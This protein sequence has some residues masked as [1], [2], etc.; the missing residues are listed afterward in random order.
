M[1]SSI[2]RRRF[3]KGTAK[4]AV[5][6]A[7]FPS[8]RLEAAPSFDL[9]IKGGTILD[10]TGGNPWKTD[11]G[12][13]GDR[14]Q[15]IGSISAGQGKKVL[16]VGGLHVSPGF[17]DIHTHSDSTLPA[18]TTADSRVR[19]GVTTEVTGNCGSSAAPRVD[20][21][22]DRKKWM[23]DEG[24]V[25]D[26][27]DVATYFASLERR[28]FSLNQAMLLGQGTIRKNIV[29]LVD[30]EA[31]PDEMKKILR[32]LEDGMDQGAIGL[33]TGLEYTPGLY[34][35]TG[36][37]IDMAR[38]VSRR[39]GLYASHIRNEE[40]G[41]LEAINE[42]IEIGRRTGVRVQIS[43]LKAAGRVNWGKQ[44]AA[45]DLI[46]SAKSEGIDILADAYPYTAYSTTLTVL[47][48]P[49][50]LDGG[51]K[52]MMGRLKDAEQRARIR[53]ELVK[54]I[55]N[56]PGDY[57]LIVISDLHSQ[58]NKQCIGMNMKQIGEM[59]SVEPVDAVL[60]LIEEE[61]GNISYVGHGMSPENV[62]MVLSHP[63]VMISSDGYSIAPTG[64]AAESKPHPRSYGTYPRAL[65]YYARDRKIFD[66]PVAIKKMTSMPADQAGLMDRGR[67]AP[68]KK[69]DIVAFNAVQVKDIA[70]YEDPHRYPQG[71]IH[72]V[73]NGKLVVENGSHTGAK[74][75]RILRKA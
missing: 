15:E 16:D 58:K 5:A 42:A 49:W 65:S 10:G 47:F 51:P 20:T 23:D 40:S 26:W 7:V 37:I 41:L 11:I 60:R 57:D 53:K 13:V 19:Q 50:V 1:N 39:G 34:T 64:K 62:E 28:Q 43:H 29:G 24:F 3:L 22:E 21:E 72:V 74:P 25:P 73:V 9:V 44:R 36:E 33:S 70:T 12:I 67:I 14:I 31:T 54:Y 32:A 2:H 6:L 52:A 59:W 27:T 17:I 55:A 18:Y 75:G 38:L 68:G 30:R 63:L 45:I 48:E 71:I 66:L 35:P 8:Y 61:E 46:V 4:A 69:A 56:D